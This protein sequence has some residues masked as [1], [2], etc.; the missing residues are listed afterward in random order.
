[1]MPV[2]WCAI[3]HNDSASYTQSPAQYE[4]AVTKQVA[5]LR[6]H[7]TLQDD[8]SSPAARYLLDPIRL[9]EIVHAIQQYRRRNELLTD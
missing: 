3:K 9:V 2:D 1:M 6:G 7:K 4:S 8:I 5:E